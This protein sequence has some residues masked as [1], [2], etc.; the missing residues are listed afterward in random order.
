MITTSQARSLLGQ[1]VVI[2][3]KNGALYEGTLSAAN[4]KKQKICLTE[5]VVH[6][7]TQGR[8]ASKWKRTRWFA[9]E[10]FEIVGQQALTDLH[11]YWEEANGGPH[12]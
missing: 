6:S 2:K 1:N 3:S 10:S 11:A 8:I 5:L 4:D 12:V 7:R 9:M